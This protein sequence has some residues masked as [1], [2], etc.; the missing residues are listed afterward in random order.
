M[1]IHSPERELACKYTKP[2]YKTQYS[3]I[4]IEYEQGFDMKTGKTNHTTKATHRSTTDKNAYIPV[5][6]LKTQEE[7]VEN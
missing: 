7:L 5:N 6:L 1:L 2:L 3:E 4:L